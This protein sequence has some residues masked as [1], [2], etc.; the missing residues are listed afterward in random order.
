MGSAASCYDTKAHGPDDPHL[1]PSENPGK[2]DRA[3]LN[4]SSQNEPYQTDLCFPQVFLANSCPF[5]PQIAR[6]SG[7]VSVLGILF[8]KVVRLDVFTCNVTPRLLP[9]TTTIPSHPFD[10]TAAPSLFSTR[11]S[12]LVAVVSVPFYRHY[13][14]P[15][16]LRPAS[17]CLS[18]SF[19]YEGFGETVLTPRPSPCGIPDIEQ[20]LLIGHDLLNDLSPTACLYRGGLGLSACAHRV[21]FVLSTDKIAQ[22]GTRRD[23]RWEASTASLS[24]TGTICIH[25]ICIRSTSPTLTTSSHSF[26]SAA[27]PTVESIDDLH[28]RSGVLGDAKGM[29]CGMGGGWA[30]EVAERQPVVQLFIWSSQIEPSAI[31]R[32]RENDSI[33]LAGIFTGP[34][35]AYWVNPTGAH[36]RRPHPSSAERPNTAIGPHAVHWQRRPLPAAPPGRRRDARPADAHCLLR[37]RTSC[38]AR[39]LTALGGAAV[40]GEG[41]KGSIRLRRRKIMRRR[42]R[43]PRG[44]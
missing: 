6:S 41:L 23:L 25:T 13:G 1:K 8:F 35:V 10:P 18:G 16:S 36:A 43:A 28:S 5:A 27:K 31:S 9:L 11:C 32:A 15:T 2:P 20:A 4:K 3:R 37:V 30:A 29:S 34:Q 22:I 14:S 33:W 17:L 26:P 39:L 12:L 7:S 38:D 40:R 24:A 44:E 42:G 21:T 19:S